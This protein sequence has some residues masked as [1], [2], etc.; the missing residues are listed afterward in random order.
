MPYNKYDYQNEYSDKEKAIMYLYNLFDKYNLMESPKETTDYNNVYLKYENYDNKNIL[1]IREPVIFQDQNI[2]PVSS[3][4]S[5]EQELTKLNP[6]KIPGTPREQL[7]GIKSRFPGQYLVEGNA[8]FLISMAYT[9][10]KISNYYRKQE[11]TN[12]HRL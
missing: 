10:N 7:F 2:K 11:K 3:D 9:L 5:I 1:P 8:E 4:S 6:P 12:Y